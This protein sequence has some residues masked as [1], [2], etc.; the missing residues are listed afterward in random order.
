MQDKTG[1]RECVLRS[2]ERDVNISTE[3]AREDLKNLLRSSKLH[4]RLLSSSLPSLEEKYLHK[5]MHH[6]ALHQCIMYE[7]RAAPK[8]H[9]R[10]IR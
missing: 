9:I 6:R 5:K 2:M 1:L 7:A 3:K 8:A 10:N 4:T